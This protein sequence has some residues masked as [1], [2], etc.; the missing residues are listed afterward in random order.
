MVHKKKIKNNCAQDGIMDLATAT[1]AASAAM[2]G[3]HNCAWHS[4]T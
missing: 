3:L 4:T 1:S 2:V